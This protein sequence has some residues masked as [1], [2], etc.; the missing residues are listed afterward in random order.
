M[1]QKNKDN[2]GGRRPGAGRKPRD[3]EPR[4]HITI[5]IRPE[6]LAKIEARKKA[7]GLS[8]GEVVDELAA[9]LPYP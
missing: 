9:Q 8:R 1:K 6:T 7:S 2:R 5:R 4:E 3:A